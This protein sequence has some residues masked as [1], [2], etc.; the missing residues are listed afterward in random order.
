MKTLT[1]L[2]LTVAALSILG[3]AHA[4]AFEINGQ[5]VQATVKNSPTYNYDI[6]SHKVVKKGKKSKRVIV[7]SPALANGVEIGGSVAN[8]TLVEDNANIAAGFGSKAIQSIGTI[9]G[10]GKVKIG[11]SV[12]NATLV[13]RNVNMSW[14]AFTTAC[15]SIGTIGD[16][17]ACD[18]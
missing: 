14:G 10:N 3:A 9:H 4:S 12:A 1:K 11:G 2:T 7:R 15:Q 6:K 8:A 13:K 16:N 5:K 18:Y 17:P